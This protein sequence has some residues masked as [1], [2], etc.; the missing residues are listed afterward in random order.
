MVDKCNAEKVLVYKNVMVALN[1]VIRPSTRQLSSYHSNTR[2][3]RFFLFASIWELA[4]PQISTMKFSTIATTLLTATMAAAAPAKDVQ[5]RVSASV[6]PQP[7][8]KSV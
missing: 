4:H 7:P 5:A 8:A 6:H 2:H 1:L 3:T